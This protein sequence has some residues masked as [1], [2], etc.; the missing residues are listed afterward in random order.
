MWSMSSR[1]AFFARL[2][3]NDAL[4]F[5]AVSPGLLSSEVVETVEH[6]RPHAVCIGAVP[7]GGVAA[8]RYLVKRLRARMPGL[9]ILVGRWSGDV[10]V[11]D[12]RAAIEAAGTS[13][14]ATTLAET[15]R[16][17]WPF[18]KHDAR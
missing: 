1:F 7:P 6:R 10:D 3:G 17:L 2:C 13:H 15:R 14:V 5:I 4:R 16:Q 18:R 9:V 11:E 12:D 8:T